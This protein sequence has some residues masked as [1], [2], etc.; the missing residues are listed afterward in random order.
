MGKTFSKLAN[1]IAFD[2]PNNVIYKIVPKD[3]NM[4]LCYVGR[5]T[6]VE[7][8]YS[9]HNSGSKHGDKKLYRTI[10]QYGGMDNFKMEVLEIQDCMNAKEANQRELFWMKKLR[11]NLNT[12]MMYDG[13]WHGEYA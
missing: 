4:K 10:R 1:L 7:R 2:Y 9:Q 12:V 11:P 3:K 6:N 8:R 5:T 13:K